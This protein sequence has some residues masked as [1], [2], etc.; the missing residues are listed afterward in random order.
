MASFSEVKVVFPKTKSVSNALS[1]TRDSLRAPPLLHSKMLCLSRETL[2][3]L[4]ITA[5]LTARPDQGFW[6]S[7]AKKLGCK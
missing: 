3:Q 1:Q 7:P 5:A 4:S 2:V 6:A